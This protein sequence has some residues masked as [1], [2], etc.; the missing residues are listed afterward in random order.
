MSPIIDD[1]ELTIDDLPILPT[2]PEEDD[3]E[4]Q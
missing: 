1:K 2:E 3:Q 4:E